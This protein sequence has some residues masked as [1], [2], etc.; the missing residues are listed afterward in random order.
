MIKSQPQIIDDIR[1]GWKTLKSNQTK[2][3][4]MFEELSTILNTENDE[5]KF[6]QDVMGV[7]PI[8]APVTEINREFM[9][10]TDLNQ[11]G[12]ESNRILLKAVE[13]NVTNLEALNSENLLDQL[14]VIELPDSKWFS[15]FYY[16]WAF[17]SVGNSPHLKCVPFFYRFT[18]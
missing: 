13:I 8:S 7:R 10:L 6:Y 4:Q 9:K 3:Q 15:I 11:K 18:R 1:Q 2:V 5:E 16:L 12:D 17:I 14:P